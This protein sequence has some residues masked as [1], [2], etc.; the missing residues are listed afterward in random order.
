MAEKKSKLAMEE[1]VATTGSA[2]E[3]GSSSPN[4]NRSDAVGDGLSDV[5]FD[6]DGDECKV[7]IF[8]GI[9]D[10]EKKSMAG[11]FN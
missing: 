9:N 7:Y 8:G 10:K 2:V 4:N 5:N 3:D 11:S 6:S 1:R